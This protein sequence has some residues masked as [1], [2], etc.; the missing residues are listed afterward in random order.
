M[1]VFFIIRSNKN[2]KVFFT[3]HGRFKPLTHKEERVDQN[4]ISSATS[5]NDSSEQIKAKVIKRYGNRKLYDTARS[6]Y[7]VLADIAKMIRN[8]EEV[9]IIDNDTKDDIT[10]ATLIQI[11]F[12]SEKKSSSPAPLKILKSIIKNGD[13][14]FSNYLADLGLDLINPQIIDENI[15]IEEGT[16]EN[17]E[18][19]TEEENTERDIA[20]NDLYSATIKKVKQFHQPKRILGA[21]SQSALGQGSLGQGSSR[22]TSKTMLPTSNGHLAKKK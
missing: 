18:E 6:S 11:I 5:I 1:K 13:G 8:E 16:E 12:G 4:I 14:S 20:T 15:T 10:T 7:V 19:N 22:E 21:L 3:F 9:R 2:K 17:T